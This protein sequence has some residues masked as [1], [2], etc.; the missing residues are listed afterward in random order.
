MELGAKELPQSTLMIRNSSISGL[1]SFERHDSYV[2]FGAGCT[3]SAIL[4]DTRRRLSPAFYEAIQGMATPFVRN[5]AT[6][7]GN[8]CVPGGRRT[9]FPVL[10]AMNARLEFHGANGSQSIP[11]E[12]FESVPEQSILTSIRVPVEEWQVSL[13]RRLGPARIHSQESGSYIFLAQTEKGFLAD[14][15][16]AFGKQEAFR[17]HALENEL[18]GSRLPLNKKKRDTALEAAALALRKNIQAGA[19]QDAEEAG[20]E[21]PKKRRRRAEDVHSCGYIYSPVDQNQFLNLFAYSL[22]LL[23]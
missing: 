23:A 16:V 22:E 8:I 15:R 21:K 13:Y 6:I 14:L 12:R 10:L 19:A 9:L 11:I 3:L 1:N 7:G 20:R 2:D 4:N 5:L 17:S 18:I